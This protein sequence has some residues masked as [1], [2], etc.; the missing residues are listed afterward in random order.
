VTPSQL[1]ANDLDRL[2]SMATPSPSTALTKRSIDTALMPPPPTKRIKRPPK[3][4]DEDDYTDALSKIIARDF[5]PGLHEVQ[6]QQEYLNALESNDE[7]WIAEAGQKLREA[8]TPLP[9]GRQRRSARNSRFSTPA[10]TPVHAGTAT[11]VA[12]KT[13]VGWSDGATP[14]GVTGSEYS[15]TPCTQKDEIDTSTLSLS[16]FQSKY[17]SEDNESF[18]ALLDTQ[19]ATRRQKHAHLWT[20]DNRIPSAR[21]IAYRER[22][23]RLLI[24]KAEAEAETANS[25]K[26]LVALIAGAT[27]ARPAKPDSWRRTK[28][29]N[30]FMF[31]ATSVDEDGIDTVAQIREASSKAGP[32]GVNYGNT[33]FTPQALNNESTDSFVPPSPS[34]NTSIIARRDAARNARSE[35]E[36]SGGE[37]P[38]VNGYAYV[39]ED[40]PENIPQEATAPEPSYRDL[41][42]GQAGDGTPNPFKIGEVRR[43]EDLHHR[44]VERDAKRKRLKSAETVRTPIPGTPGGSRS[45]NLTPAARKLL[46]RVGR[47]PVSKHGAIRDGDT[48][49]KDMWTPSSTPRRRAGV[50]DKK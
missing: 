5:F 33:R 14:S 8:M 1:Q 35:T 3:V 25:G 42:A 36:Y 49:A 24:Q 10:L 21:Q 44:M 7:T 23:Q 27:D 32:K 38:R 17:T 43:R 11:P 34:L 13:P 15:T 46:D 48:R 30:A 20:P 4:L 40:E 41:L 39:D 28:P 9:S 18:N 6:Y 45:G 16:A 31:H 12:N 22:E 26:E 37:T 47:T 2:A 29:D 50:I 19:N